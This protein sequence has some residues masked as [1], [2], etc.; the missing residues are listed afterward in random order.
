MLVTVRHSI[1]RVSYRK[2][3]QV[4]LPIRQTFSLISPFTRKFDLH[5]EE[6]ALLLNC[7]FVISHSLSRSRFLLARGED[8]Q[9][10]SQL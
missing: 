5:V 3:M 8:V 6:H 4:R 2:L 1:R 7:I 9:G 10:K